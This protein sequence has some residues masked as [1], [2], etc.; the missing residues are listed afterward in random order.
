MAIKVRL[1]DL[2]VKDGLITE[3]DLRTML[4]QQKQHGGKLGQ[5]LVRVNL[6]TEE[7]IAQALARQLGMPFNDLSNMPAPAVFKLIPRDA[8]VRLQALAVGM[9]PFAKRL[10]VAFADPTD[11]KAM[12][13]VERIVGRPLTP[14]VSSALMLRR[15]IE[16]S[17]YGLDL[18]DE[19]TS[20]FQITGLGGQVKNVQVKRPAQPAAEEEVQELSEAEL[21]PIEEAEPIVE[22]AP[23]PR[24]A[25]HRIAPHAAAAPA[26][27]AGGS[28]AGE[29]ALRMVWALADVLIEKGYFTRT[30]LTRRLRAK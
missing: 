3:S 5:H 4:A 10:P 27:D 11:A 13:E 26:P 1:G 16:Q 28:E 2:L 6:C 14:Q 24:P 21:E 12:M 8:A 25:M 9:D 29:E 18:R 15:A 23:A 30:E 20:E 7:Q 17:Y 19:G 22:A